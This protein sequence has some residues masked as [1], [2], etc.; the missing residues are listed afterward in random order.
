MAIELLKADHVGAARWEPQRVNNALLHI[1]ELDGD[2]DLVLALSSFPIPKVTNGVIEVGYLNEK[3]KFAGLP[4]FDDMSVVYKDYVDKNTANILQK[5]RYQVYDPRTGKIGLKSVYARSG[6]VQ[7]FAPDGSAE[8]QYD[9]EG[10]WPS[11]FDPGDADL[12]GEDTMNITVTLTIDKAYPS[13]GF[14]IG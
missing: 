14:D 4:T 2:D 5:W 9:I 11:G 13:A 7:L 6:Y 10:I 12:Q 1:S 3:R 8:R